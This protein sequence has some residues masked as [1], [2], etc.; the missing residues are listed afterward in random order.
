MG[1]CWSESDR[2]GPTTVKQ[3]LEGKHVKRGDTAHILQ[4]L[5]TLQVLFM[6][7]QKAFLSRQDP[8][9]VKKIENCA[10]QLGYAFERKTKKEVQETTAKIVEVKESADLIGNMKNIEEE[11][12]Q[13]PEF[14]VF[15]C[16]MQM[17][18]EMM[19]FVRALR[20][21]DWQLHRT[22][23]QLFTKYFFAHDRLNYT[24]MIPVYLAEMEKLPDSDPKIYQEFLDG[25]W[26][27]NKNQDV[28]FCALGADHA[29]EQINWS[30]KLSGGLVGITLNPNARTKFFLI[31]P[32]LA[33]PAE[34]AKEIAGTSTANE[35]THHHSLTACDETA[36][37][38]LT[39]FNKQEH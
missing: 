14:Q 2:Y 1:L 29:L 12:S 27:V 38:R 18:K 4:V 39:P 5:S 33:R 30:M 13:N 20:T 11:R 26:I 28:A 10:K 23:L 17:I 3:I 6:L 37:Q 15:R 8:L 31:A 9:L 36:P 7:Y 35:S 34:E 32:E 16:Y 19:L 22:S 24:R 21:G 25:N